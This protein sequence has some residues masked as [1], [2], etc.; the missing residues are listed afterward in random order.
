VIRGAEV[1][2]RGIRDRHRDEHVSGMQGVIARQAMEIRGLHELVG[3]YERLSRKTLRVLQGLGDTDTGV[4]RESTLR[5][6]VEEVG[7][8]GEGDSIHQRLDRLGRL[9]TS[10]T[11]EEA[12][13]QSIRNTL[14]WTG[15]VTFQQEPIVNWIYNI[16]GNGST[17]PVTPQDGSWRWTTHNHGEAAT[18][19]LFTRLAS[20]AYMPAGSNNIVWH[21]LIISTSRSWDAYH[22]D[23]VVNF[24][25]RRDPQELEKI[26][27]LQPYTWA[28]FV[29]CATS[30]M[31]R[32]RDSEVYVDSGRLILRENPIRPPIKDIIL[33]NMQDT[34]W[35]AIVGEYGTYAAP[36]TP[37]EEPTHEPS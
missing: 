31:Y 13:K 19:D 37:E 6:L 5:G 1:I 32:V 16:T 2:E 28:E 4:A 20:I 29:M 17:W 24:E 9:I 25:H 36:P 21:T 27:E 10:P 30:D 23:G 22:E 3:E 15:L 8:G 18:N 7:Y 11:N 34:E 12:I 35:R 33:N 14:E 26:E